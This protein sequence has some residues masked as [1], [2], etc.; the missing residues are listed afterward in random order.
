LFYI[1]ATDI[2]REKISYNQ[3]ETWED[4]LLDKLNIQAMS[5][6]YVIMRAC[7]ANFVVNGVPT[8]DNNEGI[9]I[10]VATDPYT[11]EQ[12]DWQV[13]N[14]TYTDVES[15]TANGRAGLS[16][17]SWDQGVYWYLAHVNFQNEVRNMLKVR[18][19]F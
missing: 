10:F 3:G 8:T 6:Q 11:I 16:C 13:G 18:D 4:G 5:D 14:D 2:V 15:I 7:V 9:H 12:Y 17:Y 19:F 1:D